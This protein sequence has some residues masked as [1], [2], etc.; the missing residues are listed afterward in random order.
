MD[1]MQRIIKRHN[2][3][4]IKKS[5]NNNNLNNVTCNCKSTTPCPLQNKCMSD[6]IVYKAE[7]STLENPTQRKH[8]IGMSSTAFKMR[9]ANHKS[10]FNNIRY[11]HVTSLS[12]FYWELVE[13]NLT[14]TVK[15]SIIRRAQTCRSLDS[16]CNLCLQEKIAIICFPDKKNLLNKRE[17]MTVRCKHK[18]KFLLSSL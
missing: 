5:R 18:N 2:N 13:N 4:I 10:S 3:K 15:W 1:N 7:I 12:N 16:P 9:L 8:Y 6:N 17:E 11:R 14:P